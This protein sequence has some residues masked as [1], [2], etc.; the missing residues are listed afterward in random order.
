MLANNLFPI[1]RVIVEQLVNLSR[2]CLVTAIV[3][4][5]A[6]RFRDP[7]GKP[8]YI[9]LLF[10]CIAAVFFLLVLLQDVLKVTRFS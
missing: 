3:A 4:I 7:E 6:I 9:R 2:W 10:G 1:P 5:H 8:D